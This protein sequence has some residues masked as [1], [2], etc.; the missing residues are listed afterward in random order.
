[1]EYQATRNIKNLLDIVKILLAFVVRC[2]D[3]VLQFPD[4]IEED[5]SQTVAEQTFRKEK[6]ANLKTAFSNFCL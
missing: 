3:D 1:M 2:L 4:F 5:L 6:A